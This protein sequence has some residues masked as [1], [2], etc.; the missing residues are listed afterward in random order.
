MQMT[1]LTEIDGVGDSM[2]K[3]LRKEGFESAE[4]VAEADRDDLKEVKG[5]GD[6]RA[7][8][9]YFAAQGAIDYVADSDNVVVT[10]YNPSTAEFEHQWEY[11][12]SKCGDG[13]WENESTRDTHEQMCDG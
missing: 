11:Y 13:P 4:D 9:I 3:E 12:C 8:D 10:H 6:Q 2:A 1:D 7:E 5:L